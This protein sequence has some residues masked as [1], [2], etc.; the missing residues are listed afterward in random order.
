MRV[1]PLSCL[2]RARQ[3]CRESYRH[4]R[5]ERCLAASLALSRGENTT[6][7]TSFELETSHT[8]FCQSMLL[9]S[10]LGSPYFSMLSMISCPSFLFI[11]L[12]I[13]FAVSFLPQASQLTKAPSQQPLESCGATGQKPEW[14]WEEFL[15]S[16]TNHCGCFGVG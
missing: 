9:V 2:R 10:L 11:Q 15:W 8:F 12:F 4:K 14:S 3:L 16:Y 5:Q 1:G 7:L 13:L 6:F